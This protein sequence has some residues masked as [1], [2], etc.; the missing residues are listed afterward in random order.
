MGRR[1]AESQIEY[2]WNATKAGHDDWEPSGQHVF[3][4]DAD[5]RYLTE[6]RG[7]ERSR[8]TNYLWKTLQPC[9]FQNPWFTNTGV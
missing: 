2:W 5:K 3:S 6:D 8:A 1:A 4:P 9:I 7:W